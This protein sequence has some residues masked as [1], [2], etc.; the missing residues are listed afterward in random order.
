MREYQGAVLFV[1]ILGIG[2]LTTSKVELVDEN[3]FQSISWSS[4]LNVS[5]QT[6]CA[7]LLSTFRRNLKKIH[8]KGVKIAQLSDCAFLW[9]KDS[10]EL[11]EVARQLFWSN[12][13]AGVL[14]RAG[15][16]FG[17]IVEPQAVAST[18]GQFVCGEAVTRAVEIER[19]GKGSRIFID[20]FLPGQVLPSFAPSAFTDLVNAAD[21]RRVDEFCWFSLPD[22]DLNGRKLSNAQIGKIADLSLTLQYSPMFRWNAASSAGQLQLA[23]TIERVGMEI[24]K[25]V[26]SRGISEPPGAVKA[27]HIFLASDPAH[28]GARSKEK[29]E[30]FR[31]MITRWLDQAQ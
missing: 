4:K 19:N 7:A 14:T 18:I 2:S 10:D 12:A 24:I 22:A 17:Q 20:A 5:N 21:F 26:R 16:S 15:M 9:S 6:F 30:S 27:A 13:Y 31:K 11:L 3:D 1:D 29:L 25:I 23:A 28:P 8:K